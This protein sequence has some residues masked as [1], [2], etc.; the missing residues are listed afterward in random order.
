[1]QIFVS[2]LVDAYNQYDLDGIDIDWEYPGQPGDD[3]NIV[4]PND[5][6]N[7]LSFLQLLRQSLPVTAKITAAAMTV[8]WADSNGEPMKDMSAF[9]QVLDWILL[10]N[11]D[12]W[13]CA[14]SRL[15]RADTFPFQF[16]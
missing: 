11:Y 6:A 13:G 9:G 8:P 2:N 15:A 14:F 3:G 10:M 5:T 16:Y 4:A 1:M 12:T 7:F